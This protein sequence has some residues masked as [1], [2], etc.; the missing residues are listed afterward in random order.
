MN[1]RETS[2]IFKLVWYTYELFSTYITQFEKL[3]ISGSF[4][5]ILLHGVCVCER[6]E[7]VCVWGGGG[8]GVIM[9]YKLR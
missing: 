7:C 4:S 6:E 1:N 5:I 3:K 8:G 2:W 9:L